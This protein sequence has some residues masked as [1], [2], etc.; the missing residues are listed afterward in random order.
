MVLFIVT[1]RKQ[2]AS[3]LFARYK[4]NLLSLSF[5]LYFYRSWSLTLDEDR[6]QRDR[7]SWSSCQPDGD[8]H[9]LKVPQ[10]ER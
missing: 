4:L 5:Q 10:D 8:L 7:D 1:Q 6:L 2:C 9:R 3:P